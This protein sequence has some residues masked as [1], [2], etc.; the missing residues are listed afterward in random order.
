MLAMPTETAVTV[1]SADTAAIASLSD[2]HVTVL[3]VVF[4]GRTVA[5]SLSVC[6][7]SSV[8]SCALSVMPEADTG[9]TVTLH[10][11][12]AS[13]HVAVM[14]AMPTETAVTVPSADTAAIASL[15]DIH[16]TVLSVV[17]CG[18]TVAMIFSLSPTNNSKSCVL[19]IISISSQDSSIILNWFQ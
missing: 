11:A 17:F 1:P 4:S 6:P 10:V 12:V 2:V 7:T 5:V 13:P 14:L 16:V 15:S 9:L 8:M 18:R 19:S 3:S